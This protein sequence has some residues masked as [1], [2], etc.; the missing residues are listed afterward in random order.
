MSALITFILLTLV[1]MA[2]GVVLA[3]GMMSLAVALLEGS[4]RLIDRIFEPKGQ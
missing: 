3:V 2:A 4:F 1:I